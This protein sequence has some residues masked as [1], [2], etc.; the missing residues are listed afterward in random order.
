MSIPA[1]MRAAVLEEFGKPL[2][3]KDVPVP[4]PGTG[5]ILVQVEFSGICHSDLHLQENNPPVKTPLPIILGHE[6]WWNYGLVLWK[7]L[8][9]NDYIW[10]VTPIFNWIQYPWW[11]HPWKHFPRYWS[12]VRGIHRWPVNFPHKDQWRRALMF[13]LICAWTND[14]VSNRDADD[15][16]RHRA[17]YDVTVM[18]RQCSHGDVMEKKRFPHTGPVW[19]KPSVTGVF[20]SQSF[21]ASL[22]IASLNKQSSCP[23]IGNAMTHHT[24]V[25]AP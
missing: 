3:F 21:A 12:F 25:T 16:R 10:S 18:D 2:V 8:S 14:W 17:N 6:G 20:Y 19:G 4:K 23:G 7:L 1:T 9:R 11:R 15:L 5:E 22:V 24:H 13:S